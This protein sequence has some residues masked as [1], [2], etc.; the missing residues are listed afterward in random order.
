VL[1]AR[2]YFTLLG[3]GVPG[4]LVLVLVLVVQQEMSHSDKLEPNFQYGTTQAVIA[5]LLL[6]FTLFTT[7]VC[8]ILQQRQ[9][10]RYNSYSPVYTAHTPPQN[11][12]DSSDE[13]EGEVIPSSS[14][15]TESLFNHSDDLTQRSQQSRRRPKVRSLAAGSPVESAASGAENN[16]NNEAKEKIFLINVNDEE[17]ENVEQGNLTLLNNEQM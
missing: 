16:H 1:Q 10:K 3:W 2:K 17:D 5:L 8:L 4:V 15:S 7:I 6:W 13:F 14:D 9:Q 11:L 12:F